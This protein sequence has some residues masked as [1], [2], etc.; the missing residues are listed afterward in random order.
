M[1][2]R[3]PQSARGSREYANPQIRVIG[4]A[5]PPF[6]ARRRLRLPGERR[7]PRLPF[8]GRQMLGSAL[9][10]AAVGG[11]AAGIYFGVTALIESD[12]T[13]AD[14]A[15][16]AAQQTEAETEA[17]AEP[18][19]SAQPAPQEEPQAEPAGAQEE[20]AQ[21]QAEPDPP[22][23]AEQADAEAEQA[24]AEP[25]P[26]PAIPPA[27]AGPSISEDP[28]SPADISGAPVSAPRLTAEPVPPGIPR[29]LADGTPYDPADA[30]TVF[31]A[32]WPI[33]TTLRLT[34]LGGATLLNEAQQAQVVGAQLLAVV[35]GREDSNADIQLSAAA[36][37]QIAVYGV[38]RIIAVQ[39]DVTAPPPR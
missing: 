31:S 25:E 1:S 10:L 17:D 11:A 37:N 4:A 32:V 39:V 15:I 30:T 20:A 9:L 33:G 35:R 8:S 36:F 19:Q 28:I 24:Q 18:A 14:Q 13:P 34:R 3:K 29:S 22:P 7:R 5:S 16:V 38:E 2:N 6:E 23:D 27:Q 12:E 21:E 26:A